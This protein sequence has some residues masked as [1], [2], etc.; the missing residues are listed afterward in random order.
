MNVPEEVVHI[1]Q[2]EPK[3][4]LEQATMAK[5]AEMTKDMGAIGS[6]H[7]YECITVPKWTLDEVISKPIRIYL[8]SNSVLAGQNRIGR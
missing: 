2:R 5:V 8:I 6:R 4:A 7:S 1:F 3:I